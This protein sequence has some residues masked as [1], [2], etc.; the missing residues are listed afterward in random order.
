M[1]RINGKEY[2]G[3]SVSISNGV[4]KVDGKVVDDST[5]GPGGILKVAIEGDPVDVSSDCSV[6]VKGTVKGSVTAGGSVNCDDVGGNVQC[7]GS[8][9]CDDISGNVM[10][11]GSISHS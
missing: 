7:G 11:G 8:V 1:I 4:V 5:P 2:H 3:N 6:D 10:A 9:N